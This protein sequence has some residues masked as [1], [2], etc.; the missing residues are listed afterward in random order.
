VFALAQRLKLRSD[1]G[2]R[3]EVGRRELVPQISHRKGLC[4]DSLS[5]PHRDGRQPARP[6]PAV[7][8]RELESHRPRR[9]FAWKRE[10]SVNPTGNA[11]PV[12]VTYT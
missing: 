8:A 2:V 3:S 1:S 7:F 5:L 11:G 9:G 6:V 12:L 4:W 10:A